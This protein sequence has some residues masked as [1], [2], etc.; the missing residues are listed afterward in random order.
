MHECPFLTVSTV[1]REFAVTGQ[2]TPVR[3]HWGYL[4]DCGR[5]CGHE[6][7]AACRE[8]ARAETRF[9]NRLVDG[10]GSPY[11]FEAR[12]RLEGVM[13]ELL[14]LQSRGHSAWVEIVRAG[15]AANSPINLRI[16]RVVACTTLYDLSGLV[17]ACYEPPVMIREAVPADRAGLSGGLDR[18]KDTASGIQGQ[19]AR[20]TASLEEQFRAL[21]RLKSVL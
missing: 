7:C 15:S 4:C 19:A 9:L 5:L 8:G 10:G 6:N 17:A 2:V 11:L 21:K 1:P 18:I 14:G 3:M 13:Q 16:L 20:R 12:P